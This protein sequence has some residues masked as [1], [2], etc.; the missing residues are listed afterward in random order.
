MEEKI[1]PTAFL[2]QCLSSLFIALLTSV[3]GFVYAWPSYTLENFVSNNT[4]LSSPMDTLEIS[5]LGSLTNIGALVTTPFCG[6]IMDRI[7]RKHAAMLFGLPSV[8]SWSIISLTRNVP[9]ILVAVG[10][11]GVGAAG[12]AV[13]SVYISE[14]SQDSIRGFLTSITV[15]A[16]FLGLLFSYIL[17]GHLRYEHVIYVHLAVSM[18]YILLVS[19]LKESPVSLMHRGKEKE[20]AQSVAFYRRVDV[21]AKEVEIELTKIRIQLDPKIIDKL[22]TDCGDNSASEHLMELKLENAPQ[23]NRETGWKFLMKSDTSKRALVSVL[24]LM[25]V[26]IL[27][28]SVVLQVY[29]EPLF[30]RAVPSMNSNQC[31]IYLALD[32]SIAS[33]LCG[34]M[35]DK[36]GR[37]VLMTWT[38]VGSGV[39]TLMLGAQLIRAWVP[40]WATAALIYGFCFIYN[41]GASVVPFVYTAEVFLPE[42]RGLGNSM[43][44]GC[45]WIMNFI[46][47]M[48]FNPIVKLIGLGPIF[49]GFSTICFLGAAY[50]H[51]CLPE[52]KGLSADEIQLLFQ[53]KRK[54]RNNT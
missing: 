23:L 1:K 13:S 51:F 39:M 33:V 21:T 5:L 10:L 29:A 22:Q 38:S 34:F 25:G 47:L 48:V 54:I 16:Y 14:I 50:S 9:L 24:T 36:V 12:Q 32:Y 26:S 43:S 28:G 27:M 20:A 19:M 3:T 7:G 46:T 15:S 53:G 31:S 6:Y 45:M 8:I 17:G 49:C 37:K 30:K 18:L 11:A 2:V 42:V 40:Q 4:V 35:L 41:L 44:T 52:T